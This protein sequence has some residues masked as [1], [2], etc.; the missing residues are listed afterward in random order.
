MSKHFFSNF[1]KLGYSRPSAN[2]LHTMYFDIFL[3]E[4]LSGID[5]DFLDFAKDVFVYVVEL[6]SFH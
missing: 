4:V 3:F 5:L 2:Q 6:L 1:D